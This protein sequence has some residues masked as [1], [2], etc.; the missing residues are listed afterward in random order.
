MQTTTRADGVTVVNDAYN[1]NPHSLNAIASMARGCNQRAVAVLARMN[2]LGEDALKAHEEP[3]RY[4]AWPD[5]DRII[6]AG[7]DE[8]AWM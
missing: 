8:A 7:G 4:A 6:L 1:A 5:L 3:G 2:E